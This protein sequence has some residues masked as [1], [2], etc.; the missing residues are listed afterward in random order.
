MCHQRKSSVERGKR[1]GWKGKRRKIFPHS[2]HRHLMKGKHE[3]VYDI[4]S[5]FNFP[6][7]FHSSSLCSVF[8]FP[9]MTSLKF[10]TTKVLWSALANDLKRSAKASR[11]NY[12]SDSLI[13]THKTS[14]R[15]SLTEIFFVG[16]VWKIIISL[17]SSV[18]LTCSYLWFWFFVL[19][20]FF[21]ASTNYWEVLWSLVS[22]TSVNSKHFFS[23]RSAIGARSLQRMFGEFEGW[24]ERKHKN[25]NCWRWIIMNFELIMHFCGVNIFLKDG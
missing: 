21:M 20:E 25:S 11:R 1:A 17:L 13:E 14:A 18:W 19:F 22:D 7:T 3:K 12:R 5:D 6:S 4:G 10:S 15:P 23:H 24:L 2:L 8:N 16:F 9:F